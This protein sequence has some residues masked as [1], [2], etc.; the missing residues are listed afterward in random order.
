MSITINGTTG[1]SGIDGSASAPAVQGSDSNTGVFFPAADTVSI[2]TNGTERMRVD[3]TGNVGIG[4]TSPTAKLDVRG[5]GLL[6][7]YG[8]T[9][10]G[11]TLRNN[12]DSS[13][14]ET[15]SF[16]DTQNNLA[17]ADTSI[18]FVHQTSGGSLMTF[19]TTPAGS[20][21]S[22]RRV[23]RLRIDSTGAIGLSGG[24]YGTSGQVLTS[25]GSGA[26]PSWTSAALGSTTVTNKTGSRATATTYQNTTNGWLLVCF[27]MSNNG[28]TFL[29]GATSGLGITAMSSNFSGNVQTYLVPP[30]WYYRATGTVL[31]NWTEGQA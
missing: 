29:I 16:I 13:V 31:S 7:M 14:A 24:N 21:S 30:G 28:V 19:A 6:G 12:D 4:T 23:E 27:S 17:T 26:S 1:I 25:G 8:G 3:S 20:R 15:T 5:Y 18:F 2:A 10:Q 11:V 22:D 9:Y